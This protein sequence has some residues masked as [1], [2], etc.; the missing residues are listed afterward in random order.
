MTVQQTVTEERGVTVRQVMDTLGIRYVSVESILHVHDLEPVVC[1]LVVEN[2]T[3]RDREEPD[4]IF[5]GET[6]TD[7]SLMGKKIKQRLLT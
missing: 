3:S 6:C 2:V 1:F 7:D 5:G 4:S